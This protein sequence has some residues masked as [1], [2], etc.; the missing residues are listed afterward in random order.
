MAAARCA[1]IAR[2]RWGF[3]LR[4]LFRGGWS[5]SS[6]AKHPPARTQVSPKKQ[7]RRGRVRHRRTRSSTAPPGGFGAAPPPQFAKFLSVALSLPVAEN[8]QNLT[9]SRASERAPSV[10]SGWCARSESR[11]V[12]GVAG[13]DAARHPR[14]SGASGSLS[15]CQ[16]RRLGPY[17]CRRQASSSLVKPKLFVEPAQPPLCHALT[18]PKSRPLSEKQSS[19]ARGWACRCDSVLDFGVL[20]RRARGRPLGVGANRSS[21]RIAPMLRVGRCGA[22]IRE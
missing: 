3:A 19:S 16:G 10:D 15:P 14:G 1:R 20:E 22:C 5:K 4:S 7:Q 13:C 12:G 11:G 9:V 2:R 17:R 8:P 21:F 18:H 6:D